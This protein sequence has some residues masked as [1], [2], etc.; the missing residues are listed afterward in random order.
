MLKTGVGCETKAN[1]Q[2]CIY[3]YMIR[4]LHVQRILFN[5][6][7]LHHLSQ[8]TNTGMLTRA[9]HEKSACRLQISVIVIY[10]IINV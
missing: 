6:F 9:R 4:F 7:I 8:I 3:K 2:V 10:L 5:V 1:V